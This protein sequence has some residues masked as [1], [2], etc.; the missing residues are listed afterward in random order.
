[1]REKTGISKWERQGSQKAMVVPHKGGSSRTQYRLLAIAC[2]RCCRRQAIQ[3]GKTH[4][5][6]DCKEPQFRKSREIHGHT[7]MA[8]LLLLF[9]ITFP[10]RRCFTVVKR[11]M[12]ERREPLRK[13]GIKEEL[14]T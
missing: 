1:M 2:K 5:A 3:Y 12:L 9:P 8:S 13:P 14:A 11:S 10:K 6:N 4:K 7:A